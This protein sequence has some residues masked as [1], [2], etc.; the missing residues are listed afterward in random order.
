M[1]D[2]STQT[3]HLA[4]Y[5]GLA[6][7]EIGHAVSTIR[8]G[9][10]QRSPGRY[11]VLAVGP[12]GSPVTTMG[13]L[14]V[15]PDLALHQLKPSTSAML[16]LPGASDWDMDPE[17]M[18]PFASAA[19]I[20][21]DAGVPVAAICGATA[22]LAR[23]GLL[24]YRDH[25]SA[26]PEYLLATGYAGTDRYRNSLAVTD[27]GLIT[28]GP[29]AP[30]EFAREIFAALDLFTPRTLDAWYRLHAQHDAGAYFSLMEG[31]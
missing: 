17:S 1:N 30:I 6:D 2:E 27:D 8:S 20:F 12:T 11:E 29:T 14:T 5:D 3:I 19:G 25:T 16:I 28:A 4:V 24:D 26:A 31:A 7:W 23:E 21:L 10:W 13:G 9:E 22:G 15:L 18:T